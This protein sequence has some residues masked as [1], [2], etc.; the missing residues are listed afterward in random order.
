MRVPAHCAFSR[1]ILTVAKFAPFRLSALALA[2]GDGSFLAHIIFAGY[3]ACSQFIVA[4]PRHLCILLP[5]VGPT[6]DIDCTFP[7]SPAHAF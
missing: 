5:G 6:D 7:Q 3:P 4:F 1:H 2:D